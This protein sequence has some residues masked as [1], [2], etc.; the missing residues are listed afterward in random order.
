MKTQIANPGDKQN[1]LMKHTYIYI[2]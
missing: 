2:W 1:D